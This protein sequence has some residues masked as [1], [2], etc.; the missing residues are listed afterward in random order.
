MPKKRNWSIIAA[1]ALGVSLVGTVIAFY[2]YQLNV[3][4]NQASIDYWLSTTY[5]QTRFYNYSENVVT[6]NCRN[7]GGMDGSFYLVV[8]LTNATV[9]SQQSYR[10][11]STMVKIPF[12]LHKSGTD[13]DSNSQ[14]VAF[15]ID[16]D[17]SGFS[18]L[19]SLEK[20]DQNPLKANSFKYS[21]L[22][23]NWNNQERCY[24]LVE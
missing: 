10:V 18:V 12:L 13:W 19:I 7:G 16:E 24:L 5:S 22:Q 21:R 1:L 2:V 20:Q 9:S 4:M 3:Q 23:C 17:V 15:T 11:N 6:A 14:N 8:T